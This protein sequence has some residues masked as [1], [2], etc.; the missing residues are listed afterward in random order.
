MEVN[1]K[2]NLC[3]KAIKNPSDHYCLSDITVSKMSV[4]SVYCK[5]VNDM[6]AGPGNLVISPAYSAFLIRI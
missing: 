5:F 6:V 2:S 1:R 3:L 4:S